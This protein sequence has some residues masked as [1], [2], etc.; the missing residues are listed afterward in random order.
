[1]PLIFQKSEVKEKNKEDSLYNLYAV[2]SG[3]VH[4]SYFLNSLIL[5]GFLDDENNGQLDNY[6]I[7][8]T[9][10][11]EFLSMF[12]QFYETSKSRE[13]VVK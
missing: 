5:D 12:I 8:E 11:D 2:L 13:K 10:I 3:Q 4:N 1:M 9:C 7:Y 6:G